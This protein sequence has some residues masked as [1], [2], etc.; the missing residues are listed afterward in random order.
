MNVG[1]SWNTATAT[2][3]RYFQGSLRFPLRFRH[4][5]LHIGGFT[6]CWQVRAFFPFRQEP[7]IAPACLLPFTEFRLSSGSDILAS[8]LP[9]ALYHFQ[10]VGLQVKQDPFSCCWKTQDSSFLAATLH[11][12]LDNNL[13]LSFPSHLVWL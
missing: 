2:T 12:L 1:G 6:L 3:D 4:L 10:T 11:Y 7:P 5:Q 8:S 9:R 13:Q